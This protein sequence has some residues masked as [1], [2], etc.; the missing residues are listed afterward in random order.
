MS[1]RYQCLVIHYLASRNYLKT[2]RQLQGALSILRKCD[3]L[4]NRK[5]EY[6]GPTVSNRTGPDRT[7]PNR[8]RQTRL[9]QISVRTTSKDV[10][11][12]DEEC[13]KDAGESMQLERA[14]KT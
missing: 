14:T 12:D 11:E 1:V 7:E 13:R 3:R 4:V 6:I 9:D 5:T 10:A 2:A 8:T